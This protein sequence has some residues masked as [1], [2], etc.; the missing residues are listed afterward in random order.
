MTSSDDKKDSINNIIDLVFVIDKSG[1]MYRITEDT[2]GGFNSM[3]ER[4]KE[5]HPNALV[6]LVLFDT[7]RRVIYTRKPI[8]E[9]EKL[10]SKEYYA[11]GCTA[12]LDA[13]GTTIN[14][15]DRT[16]YDKVLFVISTDG[17]ENSSKEFTNEDIK[18]MI[19]NHDWE[20]IFLGADI[21]SFDQAS[22][23]GIHS[24]HTGNYSKTR[25]GISSKWDSINRASSCLGYGRTLYDSEWKRDLE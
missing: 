10:T 15:I 16:D 4:E 17:Y 12:L 19:N 14:I 1:S 23:I 3:I 5:L 25:R 13:V 18:N 9:V 22:R 24:S 20:F 7:R 21:D 2:I 6:T 11:E 8:A